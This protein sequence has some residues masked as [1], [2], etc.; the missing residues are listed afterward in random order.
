MRP[1]APPAPTAERAGCASDPDPTPPPAPAAAPT[2]TAG[3][4]VSGA[5]PLDREVTVTPPTGESTQPVGAAGKSTGETERLTGVAA[6]GAAA[7]SRPA[8]SSPRLEGEAGRTGPGAR[9]LGET[10][11]P[12][13]AGSAPASVSAGATAA[14]LRPPHRR[15]RRGNRPE[16]RRGPNGWQSAD[17]RSGILIG[18]INIQSIKPKLLELN[19]ELNK[20]RYDLLFVTETWL[21]P[22]TPSRLL[23]FP[24]YRVFRAD[25]PDK[26]GY[27]GVAVLCR[28]GFKG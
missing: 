10:A 2:V 21:K 12:A 11:Q 19:H 7:V 14:E 8:V 26:S 15:T 13:A 6:A 16:R 20:R 22:S 23:S 17:I 3:D 27:G 5:V 9:Q 1:S 18:A 28:D 4:P 25:R 24:G